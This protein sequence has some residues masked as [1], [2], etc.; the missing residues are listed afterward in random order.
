MIEKQPFESFFIGASIYVVQEVGEVILAGL[1]TV[2]ATD[3]NGN[4]VSDTVLDQDS[5]VVGDDARGGAGNVL[6]IRIQDGDQESSPYHVSFKMM[7]DQ[8]NKWEVDVPL[9]IEEA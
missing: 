2:T 9:W 7:T 1:S 8:D 5:I 3:F 4:D 6:K